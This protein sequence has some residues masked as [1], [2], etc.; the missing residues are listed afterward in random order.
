M[1]SVHDFYYTV[2]S[3]L[4]VRPTTRALPPAPFPDWFCE[5]FISRGISLERV[6]EL[7]ILPLTP[8]AAPEERLWHKA[9]MHAPRTNTNGDPAPCVQGIGFPYYT[10][11][12]E[13][14]G[15]IR[16]ITWTQD[17]REHFAAE[18][19]AVPRYL[20]PSKKTVK[21][22][23][24]LYILPQ[25]WE[26]LKKSATIAC[27]IEGEAKNIALSYD[28]LQVENDV[29]SYASIGIAGVEQCLCTPEVQEISWK[30]RLVYMLFDADS[31][32]KPEVA[33][34][35]LKI[36]AFLLSRGARAV[37]SCTWKEERGKGY[38]DYQVYSVHKGFPRGFTLSNLLKRAVP[39][40]RKYAPAEEFEG[41]PLQTYCRAIARVPDLKQYHIKP[42]IEDISAIF[43]TQGL[44]PK[45]VTGCLDQEMLNVERERA[46]Q[47]VEKI[48]REIQEQYGIA[49]VPELP[50]G[51]LPRNGTLFHHET[52]I[53]N[54]FV[55]KK[56]ISTA[57]PN[58]QDYYLLGF[59]GKD[60]EIPSN[61][62]TKYR[63][64]ADLFNRNQEILCDSSAR[65][66]QQ[67]I[68]QYWLKN[69]YKPI[70]VVSKYL[71]TGWDKDGIFRLP[72][73]DEGA[74]YEFGIKDAF[75][76]KGSADIARSYTAKIFRSHHAALDLLLA[77]AAPLVGLLHLPNYTVIKSGTGGGGKTTGVLAAL[78][79]YGCVDKLKFTMD[80]TKVGQELVCS[81]YRDLPILLDEGNTGSS[82]DGIKMMQ[83]FINTIYG[84]ES[85]RGR[86]RGGIE[87]GDITLR[88][89]NEYK[90]LLFLTSERSLS[91]IMSVA[92]NMTIGGIYRRVLEIPCDNPDFPLWNV[93]QEKPFFD[94]LYENMRQHYGHVGAAWLRHISDPHVQHRIKRAYTEMLDRFGQV[95]TLKG[96]ENLWCLLDAIQPEVETL[97]NLERGT[98]A[99]NLKGFIQQILEHNQQQID[100]QL[101]NTVGNFFDCLDNFMSENIG[102]FEG[103]ADQ[104][105]MIPNRIYGKYERTEANGT[106]IWITVPAM[107]KLCNEYGL[108]KTGLLEQLKLRKKVECAEEQDK[109]AKSTVKVKTVWT[110]QKWIH[111]R[112]WKTYHFRPDEEPTPEQLH[113]PLS[114]SGNSANHD[115]DE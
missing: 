17:F 14:F 47:H 113:I 60:L 15:R 79:M 82:G 108:N 25:D 72:T 106:D 58:S 24:H 29:N 97:L 111:S 5:Y 33:H 69:K 51:F 42:L 10:H 76:V 45:D 34:A 101:Q 88:N 102:S 84:F 93:E 52:P 30:N 6:Q 92:K 3:P 46:K 56:Y 70:P 48:T 89:V 96:T 94:E 41:F 50:E 4:E 61:K 73:V 114:V 16:G 66:V 98:I 36:A 9:Y 44:K 37:K 22:T 12:T 63:D 57:D 71:N 68:S 65:A 104:E 32:R 49:Y 31:F 107:E 18:N 112:N 39:T 28:V 103:L 59:K 53:C 62:F 38:D 86:A 19:K 54:M 85:G 78:A 91:T 35:E 81:L 11:E 1:L 2:I 83:A 23:S 7:G 55:I 26:K 80:V 100:D 109:R 27:L 67:Y 87:G 64:I 75:H 20:S 21:E 43:K 115:E 40:F 8:S 74:E 95:W 13:R 105:R 90:G 77:M 110:V 99:K